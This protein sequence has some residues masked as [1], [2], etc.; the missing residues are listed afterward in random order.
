P[1]RHLDQI[2]DREWLLYVARRHASN[3]P[4]TRERWLNPVVA[5]LSWCSAAPRHWIAHV[6]P[7]PRTN[8]VRKPKHRR[9]RR[10]HEL[11][12]EL[13]QRMIEHAAPHLVGQLAAEWATGARVSSVLY[14]CR[15]CDL[16]L[17]PG[18]EQITFHNTKT[19]EPVVAALHAPAAVLMRQY[20]EWR[21]NV[22]D[23]EAPL[24]VTHR[25]QPYAYNGKEFGGQN[26]SAF[27]GMKRRTIASLRAA[28]AMEAWRLRRDGRRAEAYEAIRQAKAAAS[29]IAQVTQHWFRHGL[30]TTLLSRGADLRSVMDQGGWL[31]AESVLG[32]THDVPE[33]RRALV[34]QMV[35]PDGT[36]LTRDPQK[37]KKSSS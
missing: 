32:Y 29:L 6:P 8:A 9:A 11:T 33:R 16:S 31:T 18:R 36:S 25:K 35:P 19:G 7:F 20:L 1:E 13:I 34:E 21:S 26:K 27:A 30:A 23:R 14:G 22:Y 2:A 28:G 24:F 10:V 3:A 5:F 12:P 4:E 15:V 37:A 17:V